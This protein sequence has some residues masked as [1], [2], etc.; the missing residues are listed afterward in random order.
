MNDYKKIKIARKY[1]NIQG[2]YYLKRSKIVPHITMS[3][4]WL[5]ELGFEAGGLITLKLE[6]G[7]ITITN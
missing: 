5:K 1:V 2:S 4:T 6:K 7:L 3:G